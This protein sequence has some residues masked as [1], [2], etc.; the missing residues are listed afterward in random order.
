MSVILCSQ[1]LL[2]WFNKT[3]LF[4]SILNLDSFGWVAQK[5]NTP[6]SNV[7][8][9]YLL[10]SSQDTFKIDLLTGGNCDHF[11]VMTIKR[12]WSVWTDILLGLSLELTSLI[13][14]VSQSKLYI[15]VAVTII[16][17]LP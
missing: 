16:V 7:W 2:D 4:Y 11:T 15:L 9:L 10:R 12:C 8:N 3:I 1:G 17:R 13:Q 6:K 14:S 5:K